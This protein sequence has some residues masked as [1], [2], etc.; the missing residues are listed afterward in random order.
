MCLIPP[1]TRSFTSRLP[2]H[3]VWNAGCFVLLFSIFH[4]FAQAQT[5]PPGAPQVSAVPG[6]A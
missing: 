6:N 2:R 1:R 4:T 5:P 3:V